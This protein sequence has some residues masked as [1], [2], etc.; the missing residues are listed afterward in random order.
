MSKNIVIVTSA[1]GAK[2]GLVSVK[3]R[4]DQTIIGLHSIREKIPNSLLIF[5]DCS[6][7]DIT[8]YKP[9][10]EA[11]VDVYI[12]FSDNKDS[13]YCSEMGLKSHAELVIFRSCL[14]YI[15]DNYDLHEIN[16]IFKIHGR[17]KLDENFNLRLH[18]SAIGKWVFKQSRQSHLSH[19][20]RLYETRLYS[21][22]TSNLQF[23]VDNFQFMFNECSGAFQI[24]HVYYKWINP[25]HVVEV[26]FIGGECMVSPTGGIA[27]D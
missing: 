18:E 11:L 3:D 24:E 23:Y 25:E 15:I 1:V 4:F 8:E 2:S 5:G 14:Q 16:R 7:Q 20:L 10:I 13:I 9:Q 12:D 22:H 26:P 19:D 17:C 21:L 6:L 27:K